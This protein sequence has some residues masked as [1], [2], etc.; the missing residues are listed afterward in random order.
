M[1]QK[2]FKRTPLSAYVMGFVLS[3]YLGVV[4]LTSRT[5]ALGKTG[6]VFPETP[7]IYTVW[8]GELSGV[9]FVMPK[10]LRRQTKCLV[11]RHRWT[12]FLAIVAQLFGMGVI[13]GSS[14]KG[15]VDKGGAQAFRQMLRHIKAGGSI[16]LTPDGPRGPNRVAQEGVFELVAKTGLPHYHIVPTFTH[17]WQLNKRWDHLIIPKPFGRINVALVKVSGP[18]TMPV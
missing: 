3:C 8:H 4:K 18:E 10:H 6:H 9:V 5:P 16:C 12:I 11:S 1:A 15:K 14:T 17:Y 13:R 7:A 2:N